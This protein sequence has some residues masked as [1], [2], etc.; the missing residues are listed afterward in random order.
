MGDI[1]NVSD[2]EDLHAAYDVAE[3][4][5]NRQLKL[6]VQPRDNQEMHQPE[7]KQIDSNQPQ[8]I[9]SQHLK[10]E[11]GNDILKKSFKQ[12]DEQMDQIDS[13]IV[14]KAIEE[15]MNPAEK[16]DKDE[17]MSEDSDQEETQA[18]GKGKKQKKD[19]NMGGLPRKC[20][21]K[22]IKKE[23]D[24]Q[25]TNIFND[26]MNCKELGESEQQ[27]NS[28]EQPVIHNRVECDGCG[29]APIVGVRYKCSVCKN[30]DFCQM[31][32]ERRGHEH[33]FLK[34]YKPEQAPKAMFTV[35]DE[36][37]P[38]AKADIEQEA[39]DNQTFFRNM[40]QGFRGGCGNR[41]G[42]GG[43]GGC[44]RGGWK[45]GG[46]NGMP[47]H[48]QHHF[49]NFMKGMFG[50]FQGNSQ[51]E[52]QKNPWKNCGKWSEWKTK[53]AVVAL[54]PKEALVGKPG[55]IIFANIEIRNEMNWQW[56]QGATL[57]SEFSQPVTELLEEVILPI[58]FEVM[59]NST[60]KLSIPIKVRDA[61]VAT[62]EPL[63][64]SF[65]F[66]GRKGKPF[67]EKINIKFKVERPFN[68]EEVYKTALNLFQTQ[69]E[70]EM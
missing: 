53:K 15:V 11:I 14:K 38:N 17:S 50:G 12:E 55:E 5:M 45:H 68:E 19:K 58:D 64:A 31:C 8:K 41:G 18:K 42:W 62:Q 49:G 43:R 54:L 56:K 70:P 34:I 23:L 13:N 21:K 59:E 63:E 29:V 6:K 52:G 4:F 61:A 30:F 22:L 65:G 60:F 16:E 27:I 69:S 44:R 32:E 26:L 33:A 7:Q 39:T 57:I 67:G 1:I 37:I 35:I 2:D 51:Q 46:Q 9:E 40:G 10:G 3:N 20:F 25:C 66:V 36:N 48:F 24:K 28:G 47:E